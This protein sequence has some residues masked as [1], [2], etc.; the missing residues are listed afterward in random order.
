MLKMKKARK[1]R[2]LG[3]ENASARTKEDENYREITGLTIIQIQVQVIKVLIKI[4][5]MIL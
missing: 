4:K 2:N 5:K 1:S 3:R